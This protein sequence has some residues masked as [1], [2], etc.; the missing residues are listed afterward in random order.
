MRQLSELEEFSQEEVEKMSGK[1]SR[2][3]WRGSYY[4]KNSRSTVEKLQVI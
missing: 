3:T 2:W 4:C 1:A